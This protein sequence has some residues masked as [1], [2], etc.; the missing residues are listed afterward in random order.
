M[1]V[2]KL[3]KIALLALI[4]AAL[5]ASAVFAYGD[6]ENVY[7]R[8]EKLS[9]LGLLKGVGRGNYDM[10]RAP[11]R[12]ESVVMVIRLLGKEQE[13]LKSKAAPHRFYD[14]PEWAERYITYAY[15]SGL[16]KGVSENYFGSNLAMD[17]RQY[18]TFL[19]RALNYSD[20]RG[21]FT[22]DEA[23][24][25][26]SS[27]GL[28]D[29][30]NDSGKFL[31]SDM[32]FLSYNALC[33][34]M[35]DDPPVRTLGEYLIGSGVFTDAQ[36]EKAAALEDIVFIRRNDYEWKGTAYFSA[37]S[38]DG[39]LK[40]LR[41]AISLM[42]DE[43]VISVPAGKEKEY[44]D[45]ITLQFVN[46]LAY[47]REFQTRY[48]YGSGTIWI[49][50]SYT[51]GFQSMAY[52]QNPTVPV[53]DEI[54][55]LAMNGVGVYKEKFE[56]I[57]SEYELVKAIHD[58]T[59]NKLS[60]DDRDRPGS[61]DL[62][63]ALNTNWAT[64]G[65]YSAMFQFFSLL[66]GPDCEMVYGTSVNRK[67]S[68]ENHAWNLVKVDGNWY[69]VDVTWN[70]PVVNTGEKI[71][72]YDYFLISDSVMSKDHVWEKNSYPAAKFSWN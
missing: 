18:A 9:Q 43:V 52:L 12:A 59:A 21:D 68:I 71:V 14:V 36:W 7:I 29:G 30:F 8:A 55:A 28:L 16:S 4:F 31:R 27:I 10:L 53:S 23:M 66:G 69:N 45:H 24:D 64:C 47:A 37:S 56:G 34:D 70:D 39:L 17:A 63:G 44:M 51:K 42:P 6:D 41:S 65:G 61:D 5:S 22:Y 19:L 40:D 54:K 67:G 13:A 33:A 15:D 3:A 20:D 11:T 60:Y 2:G 25:F 49:G 57:D 58:Y 26:A 72:R 35:N 50:V 48:S 1:P 46:L 62:D 38:K 32:I